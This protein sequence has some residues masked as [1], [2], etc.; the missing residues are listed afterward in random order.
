MLIT[1]ITTWTGIQLQTK[2]QVRPND[3]KP[4][5]SV[6]PGFCQLIGIN[7]KK[8][9]ERSFL[10]KLTLNKIQ[11]SVTKRI[12]DQYSLQ[13]PSR[14]V[15]RR[16]RELSYIFHHIEFTLP[17]SHWIV[18]RNVFYGRLITDQTNRSA[19]GSHGRSGRQTQPN[20]LN[21]F[22]S[23][24]RFSTRSWNIYWHDWHVHWVEALNRRLV[25]ITS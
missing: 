24:N 17:D 4:G 20:C 12:H 18:L 21:K 22:V 2:W 6:L 13:S 1:R 8:R 7:I 5:R 23:R 19:A 25:N 3:R 16:Y 15:G 11:I 9:A 10:S 14:R